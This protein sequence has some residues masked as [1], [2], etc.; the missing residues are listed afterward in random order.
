MRVNGKIGLA[1]ATF[2]RL[3][4]QADGTVIGTSLSGFVTLTKEE[5]QT[6]V[7]RY[8]AEMARCQKEGA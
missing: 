6:A 8:D 1:Y 7:D 5:A 2:Y 3:A 4:E